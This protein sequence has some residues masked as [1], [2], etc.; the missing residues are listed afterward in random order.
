MSNETQHTLSLT[1]RES[2]SITGINDVDEFNDR[3]IVAVCESS[4][5]IISGEL[6]HIEE[7]SLDSGILTVSGK[8]NSLTYVEKFTSNSLLKRLFGG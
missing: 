3:E 1:D 8:I 4:Q 5:L 2:L 7:L 6:L